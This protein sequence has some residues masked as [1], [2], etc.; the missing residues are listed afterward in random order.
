[1]VL[2]KTA[3]SGYDHIR[4]RIRYESQGIV[5]ITAIYGISLKLTDVQ[6]CLLLLGRVYGKYL[7]LR[8]VVD[9][10]V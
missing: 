1:M 7:S 4:V 3:C 5:A 10:E 8:R 9:R 6:C 2:P